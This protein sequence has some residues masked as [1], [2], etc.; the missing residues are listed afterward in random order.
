MMSWENEILRPGFDDI[1]LPAFVKRGSGGL[2]REAI[3]A[4]R[5]SLI[6]GSQIEIDNIRYVVDAVR[7]PGDRHDTLELTL[8]FFGK[9]HGVGKAPKTTITTPKK[10][11]PAKAASKTGDRN[12]R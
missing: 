8:A 4:W 9:Q 1:L 3:I 2:V 7:D 10:P 12:G 11:K 5:D 6:V